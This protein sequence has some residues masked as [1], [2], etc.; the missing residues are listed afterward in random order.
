MAYTSP[1][2]IRQVM[3]KL[4]SS[5]TDTDIQ[6]HIDKAEAY[7]NA[8]V[9]EVYATPF[10]DPTP[11]LIKHVTTDLAVYFLSEDLYSSQQPNMDEY[12]EKRFKRVMKMIDDII[13]G[14]LLIGLPRLDVRVT[15]FETTND[16]EPIFTLDLP[17]W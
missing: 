4:P 2:D 7:L 8:L 12:Q 11:P 3:R 5:I 1:A 13:L 16:G 10:G 6:F 17:Q 9:G 15:S 14:T